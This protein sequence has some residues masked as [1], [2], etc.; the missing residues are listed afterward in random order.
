MSNIK[1]LLN[2]I[3]QYPRDAYLSSKR[4]VQLILGVHDECWPKQNIEIFASSTAIFIRNNFRLRD[5]EHLYLMRMARR[6]NGFEDPQSH[7]PKHRRWTFCW[8]GGAIYYG[9]N[10]NNNDVS[11]FISQ[12]FVE[13][14]VDASHTEGE[15]IVHFNGPVLELIRQFSVRFRS[16]EY[17]INT[18]LQTRPLKEKKSYTAHFAFAI[19]RVSGKNADK[20][21]SPEYARHCVREIITMS[22]FKVVF[23]LKDGEVIMCV[24][25]K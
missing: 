23:K 1:T 7:K 14:C 10:A 6:G 11:A 18:G 21:A 24:V 5:N 20:A 17:Y 9:K 2:E 22:R 19:A 16:G 15:D 3:A 13:P 12:E 8:E 4:I 25:P